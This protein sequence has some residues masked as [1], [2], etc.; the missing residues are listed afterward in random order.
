MIRSCPELYGIKRF[1][2]VHSYLQ[3]LLN[4]IL[5]SLFSFAG[6]LSSDIAEKHD[7]LWGYRR[8]PYIR[9]KD[10]VCR[11]EFCGS[12][13]EFGLAWRSVRWWTCQVWSHTDKVQSVFCLA[14]LVVHTKRLLAHRPPMSLR[15]DGEWRSLSENWAENASAVLCDRSFLTSSFH[16]TAYNTLERAV[17]AALMRNRNLAATR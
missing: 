3:E 10:G 9:Q 5:H 6:I 12:F 8:Q 7:H 16:N 2:E 14:A 1:G 13:P 17:L 4:V 15:L 11:L